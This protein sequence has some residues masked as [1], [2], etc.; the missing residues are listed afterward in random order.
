MRSR[1]DIHE[2][3][4]R[5]ES[6]RKKLNAVKRRLESA[7]LRWYPYDTLLVFPVLERLLAGEFSYLVELAGGRPVLDI[8]CG[9]GDMAFL[10][11]TLGCRVDAL[12]YSGANYNQMRGVRAIKS[13]LGS[14]VEIYDINLDEQPRLPR[15]GYGLTFC[16]GL[17]YHLKNPFGLLEALSRSTKYCLLST[18]IAELAPDGRTR[19]KELPVAYLLDE[20]ETN[21]DPTNFWIFSEAGL[22]RI[23]KRAGWE[24]CAYLT[25]GCQAGSDPSH[26]D[27]DQ[28]AFCLLRSP[29]FDRP[30]TVTLLEGWHALEAGHFRWTE[31]RF[32]VKLE[33]ASACRCKELT[34][35][36]YLP[37][38]RAPVTLQ[39]RVN[40]VDLAPQKFE[41][42]GECL[43]RQPVPADLSPLQSAEIEFRLDRPAAPSPADPR[44]LGVVVSFHREGCVAGDAN[45]PLELL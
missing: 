34:F 41:K 9:D 42:A 44:E 2:I 10:L 30:W 27:R 5:A 14:S 18:R 24:I 43:Y 19:L 25:T 11:E 32:S 33:T 22:R 21:Q 35:T 17:L 29:S 4:R 1:L 7:E 38:G 31:G 23:L 13:A 12:D 45:L 8:G 16:L 15:S 28:R 26:P 36:F 3:R 6:F 20:L 40:G 37:E 39:A